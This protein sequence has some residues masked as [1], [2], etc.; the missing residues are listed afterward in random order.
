VRAGGTCLLA[1]LGHLG[2]RGAAAVARPQPGSASCGPWVDDG[3][4]SR[5]NHGWQGVGVTG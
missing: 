1:M 5:Y 4:V 2:E 3:A